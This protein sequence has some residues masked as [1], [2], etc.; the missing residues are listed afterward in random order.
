MC[1]SMQVFGGSIDAVRFL[2]E[3]EHADV[4]APAANSG[5]TPL[6]CATLMK[7]AMNRVS[8]V[9]HEPCRVAIGGFSVE[10]SDRIWQ[11]A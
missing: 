5:L 2:V 4:N 11:A 10:G 9:R 8:A 3:K 7:K 1:M 6:M